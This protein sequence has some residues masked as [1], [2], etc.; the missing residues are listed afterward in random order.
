M[1]E[2]SLACGFRT[3]QAGGGQRRDHGDDA[4]HDQQLD[5]REAGVLAIVP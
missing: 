4:H 3:Q 2:A 1:A 5:E